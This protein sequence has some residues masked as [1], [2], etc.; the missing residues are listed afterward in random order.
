MPTGSSWSNRQLISLARNLIDGGQLPV[1]VYTRLFAGLGTGQTCDLCRQPITHEHV[2][3]EVRDAN[4]GNPLNFHLR[5]H[6]AW[7]CE[8]IHRLPL[9]GLL[10]AGKV[11]LEPLRE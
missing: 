10:R 11:D 5:C 3:Y 4:D 2:E 8:C 7:Q 1:A 9:K 6:Q